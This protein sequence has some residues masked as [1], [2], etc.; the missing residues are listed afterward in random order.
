[1]ARPIHHRSFWK[2]LWMMLPGVA[3]ADCRLA[4]ANGTQGS[5]AVGTHWA[6]PIWE[7]TVLTAMVVSACA[8]V[9]GVRVAAAAIAP[10]AIPILILR[11]IADICPP[12]PDLKLAKASHAVSE[13]SPES[14]QLV[15]HLWSM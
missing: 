9:T 11:A 8:T 7:P 15:G 5:R 2:M 12:W 1:M 10:A 3:L 13:L 14:L 6:D 4:A